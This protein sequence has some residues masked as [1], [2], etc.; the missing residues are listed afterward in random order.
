[1]SAFVVV[2]GFFFLVRFLR[3]KWRTM[4]VIEQG[5]HMAAPPANLPAVPTSEVDL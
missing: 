3:G 5:A 2:L 4:R 1:M